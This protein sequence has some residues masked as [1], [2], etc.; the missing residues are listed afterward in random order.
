MTDTENNN[1]VVIRLYVRI[2]LTSFNIENQKNY[3]PSVSFLASFMSI[4]IPFL[5]ATTKQ[6]L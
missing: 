1:R 6:S 2:T 4:L 5:K 3:L